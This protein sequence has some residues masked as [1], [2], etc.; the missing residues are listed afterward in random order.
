MITC[1]GLVVGYV[2]SAYVQ[3][4]VNQ[5]AKWLKHHDHLLDCYPSFVVDGMEYFHVLDSRVEDGVVLIL[6][7]TYDGC[8]MMGTSGG[9][10]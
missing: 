10:L 5:C 7:R 2:T 4:L 9:S 1:M 3:D 6:C 8:T